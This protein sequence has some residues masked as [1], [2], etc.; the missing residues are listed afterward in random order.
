VQTPAL[1]H[2]RTAAQIARETG[3]AE[4]AAWCLE[5]RAWQSLTDG[6]YPAPPS[7]PGPPSAPRHEVAVP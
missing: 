7:W 2:L 4:I 3:H 1:A 6:D 5:T